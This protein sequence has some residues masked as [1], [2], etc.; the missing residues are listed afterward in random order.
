MGWFKNMVRNWLDIQENPGISIMIQETNTFEGN[1]FEN[2][3]WY[4]GSASEL[5]QYYT[6]FDDYVGNSRFW[7]AQ[8]TEGIKFRKIHTGLPK[9]M[10]NTIADILIENFNGIEIKGN[11]KKQKAWE[12]IQEENSLQDL[13]YDMFVDIMVM[14]D[15]AFKIRY[16]TDISVYPIIEFYPAKDVEYERVG[17]RIRAVIFKT[18][19]NN[20]GV[21][22]ILKERYEITGKKSV[23]YKLYDLNDKEVK[24]SNVPEL[25]ELKPIEENEFQLAIPIIPVKSKTYRGRGESLFE[26]K[27]ENF[28]S[29][30]EVWS[31]WIEAIR[32]NRTVTY[33]P[34]DLIPRDNE[35]NL[36][37]PNSFDRRFVKIEK[38]TKENDPSKVQRENSDFDYEG[39][40]SSY[41]TA[42]DLCLN[43][44]I[45]P[46]T[47]GIDTKKLDNS[48]AQREKEKTT[49]NTIKKYIRT[50]TPAL[51]KLAQIAINAYEQKEKEAISE[52]EAT[53]KFGEYANSSFEAVVETVSKAR[54]GETIMSIEQ[55]VEELYGDSKS[56]EEKEKEVK[57]LKK[58]KG[59]YITDE[60]SVV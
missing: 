25:K 42:L 44:K 56:K 36:L 46:S 3:M 37:S 33:I 32:D 7:G 41:C 28:D 47:L 54:P 38:S 18:E 39:M 51:N 21:Q 5:H 2:E 49:L 26:G 16:D 53:A 24:L 8:A 52:I 11:D 4:R 40:L 29:F 22:Y 10:V 34:E 58:E 17:K 59:I 13:L 31:Q 55:C 50:I 60:P 19:Y 9:T 57:R 45:S 15:G 12:K 14:G 27:K 20:N 23:S 48:E 6:Q 1:C 43:G 35:G 30:D